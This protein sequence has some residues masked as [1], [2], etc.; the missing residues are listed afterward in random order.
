[1]PF[2]VIADLKVKEGHVAEFTRRI[3]RHAKS[4]VTREPYY[5]NRNSAI[6]AAQCSRALRSPPTPSAISIPGA[7][8][9]ESASHVC[10]V[11]STIYG[12]GFPLADAGSH[13]GQQE[14]PQRG[15][16]PAT[17][18]ESPARYQSGEP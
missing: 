6:D 12:M 9:S 4:T 15:R 3:G 14:N 11:T 2:V 1:M 5:A 18:S 8:G 13:R 7:H 17:I 16:T 10:T